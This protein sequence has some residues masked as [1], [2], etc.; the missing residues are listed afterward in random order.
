M[1]NASISRPFLAHYN[2][3]KNNKGNQGNHL[4]NEKK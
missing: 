4:N 2:F 3:D 1:K